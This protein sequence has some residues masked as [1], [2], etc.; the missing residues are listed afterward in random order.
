MRG[1]TSDFTSSDEEEAEAWNN[2]TEIFK[3]IKLQ[4][5]RLI[6]L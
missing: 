3:L 1:S 5:I 2:D 4:I 6:Y